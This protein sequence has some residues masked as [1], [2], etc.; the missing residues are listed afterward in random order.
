MTTDQTLD[1]RA[2]ADPVAAGLM[3]APGVG[4]ILALTFQGVMDDPHR[5]GGDA[6]RA[7]AFLGLVPS[8]DSSA[9][10]QHKGHIT[11]AGPQRSPRRA[12]ASQ[13]GHLARAQRRRRAVAHV[14]ADAGR[15]PRPTDCHRRAGP[16]ARADPLCDVARSDGL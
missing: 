7:S 3:T 11:K 15:P 4:P 8:E 1:A 2:A 10:R 14:G 5:F 13:L 6:G 9:E 12:R 16:A